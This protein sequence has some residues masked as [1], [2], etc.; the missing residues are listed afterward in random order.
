MQLD[1]SPYFNHTIK[2][3]KEIENLSDSEKKVIYGINEIVL[4]ED[5]DTEL[6]SDTN[7]S[8]NLHANSSNVFDNIVCDGQIIP[9]FLKNIKT[10]S[11]MGFTDYGTVSDS[12]TIVN[13]ENEKKELSFVL[14]TFH[15]NANQS[16]ENNK[17]KRCVLLKQYMGN[18]GQKHNI[19]S[20]NNSF[21][22]ITD[23][24]Q[25][26]LPINLSLHVMSIVCI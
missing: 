20:Y 3:N 16:V 7:I 25:I 19:F 4:A 6:Y 2:Y 26:I 10:I 23:I 18:D 22:I 21:D 12:M 13:Y 8:F 24:K 14:K 15:T 17:T 11:I 1:L 5:F 9:V